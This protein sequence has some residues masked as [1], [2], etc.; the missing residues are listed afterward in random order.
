MKNKTF[1]NKD[2]FLGLVIVTFFAALS[3]TDFSQGIERW[4]YDLGLNASSAE[5]SP[6]V[7]V[8]AI[9]EKSI[10]TVGR[11]PWS[12]HI[13]ADAISK[14]SAAGAKVVGH[15]AFFFEPQ[16]DPGLVMINELSEYMINSGLVS[17]EG[18][19]NGL[20]MSMPGS[21]F[22][23][24][25]E[26]ASQ[27]KDVGT[28]LDDIDF[29]SA[30]VLGIQDKIIESQT[31][32]D[33][34]QA[35]AD[36]VAQAENVVFPLFLFLGEAYGNP[37][38]ESP[39]YILSTSLNGVFDKSLVLPLTAYAMQFPIEKVGANTQGMGHLNTI[40]DVDGSA[41]T[42]ALVVDYYGE[43][44]P[45]M[46]LVLAAKSLNL[47]LSEILITNEPAVK[48]GGLKIETDDELKM[49]TFYYQN[50]G[51]SPAFTVNS[52]SDFYFGVIPA[53]QFAGKTVLI[54]ATATGLGTT[55]VTPINPAM[56]PVL[57]LAH[58]VSSILQEDFFTKPS[59]AMGAQLATF[60]IIALF[61]TAF[62]PRLNAQ[63]GAL[64]TIVLIALG[65]GA[66]FA[67]MT[68]QTLWIPLMTPLIMLIVGYI[69]LTTK[70]FFI[71]EKGKEYADQ[72]SAES[73]RML[74]LAFQ[75]QGQ[76]DMAFDKFRKC[77]KDEQLAESLYSLALDYER[78]RA[79]GKSGNVYN[80]IYDFAPKFKDVGDRLDKSKKMEE[81]IIINPGSSS[82]PGATIVMSGEGVENPM[83][84]RY[85]IMKEL[86]KGAM[87]LVYL[88]KDPKIDREVAIKT[89]ALSQE[90][91]GDQL[92]DVK[93]RFFREAETA[94]R[95]N[96]PNIVTILDVGEEQ[97]LAFIAMEFLK[98]SDLADNVKP[99]ALLAPNLVFDIILKCALALDYAHGFN[100]V[101][102]DI[103]PANIMYEPNDKEVK[104]TDFGIARITDA[105]KTKTGTIL[106]TPSYMSPEQLAGK[107][108]DGR[109]DLFSLTVMF[110]QMISGE[111]PFQGDS[112]ATLMFQI[113]NEPHPKI[114]SFNPKLPPELELFIDKG[115]AKDPEKRF[116]SGKALAQGLKAALAAAKKRRADQANK[117]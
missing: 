105:N 36:S 102:R 11:W 96:H 114:R 44:Y 20:S 9:D 42:E 90:F 17:V 71:S 33:G 50:K 106:G 3:F 70:R 79:F 101:H 32:L 51:G 112:M 5:P 31:L 35:L 34:D 87:G 27:I 77:P 21:E 69:L 78:K 98:G 56:P 74:G 12:R 13:H 73:N 16:Q 82:G 60:V 116:A 24:L 2:W 99:D 66:H 6:Q 110:Y 19:E 41:R 14:L 8:L 100:V 65:I 52:F 80:Y 75:G 104:I 108:V 58:T 18:D 81:T 89:M 4:A 109:S 53:E 57:S 111:L 23:T 117:V 46:A 29:L 86:G 1:W 67:L 61:L 92:E 40:L 97:D 47:D 10:E 93:A 85:E 84:G 62:L 95:L 25:T 83:L 64:V 113:A 54:G 43:Y 30:A 107:K 26:N 39:D 115:L 59:W 88:G 68:T 49:N 103:K 28:L 91:E 38:T 72:E 15:T 76:L 48:I 94:G 63:T 45:S 55:L 22:D 7:V 37:E